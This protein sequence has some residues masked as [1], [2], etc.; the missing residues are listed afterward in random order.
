MD[1][2]Q[3]LDSKTPIA[4][5]DLTALAASR[6]AFGDDVLAAFKTQA[7]LR[8]AS[9]QAV[10]TAAETAGRDS[11]LAS[12]QRE[13]DKHTRERDEV[14]RL[15]AA[16]ERRTEQRNFV[17][18]SQSARATRP[19]GTFLGANLRE[20]VGNTGAGSYVTPPEHAATF[21]DRLA[22]ESIALSSGLR[23][24]TTDRDQLTVPRIE[25]D[26]VAAWTS[27]GSEISANDPD[28]D[29][30]TATPRKLAARV[31]VSNELIAD[32]NPSVVELLEHQ[33]IRALS[34]ELDRSIFKGSG[35]PPAIRG[36]DNVVGKLTD[37]SF[38]LTNLDDFADAIASLAAQNATAT[39]IVMHPNTWGTLTKLKEMT[40]NSNKPVLQTSAGSGAQGVTRAIYGVP[41]YVSS[42]LLNTASPPAADKVYIY[43]ASQIVLVRRADIRVEVDRS[44][45]FNK[46]QSEIR[47]ILR[48]DLVVPNPRAVFVGT[49]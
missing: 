15:A 5:G 40:S 32:S 12:E 39:A 25:S 47:A 9:A 46:D 27:E 45:L 42:Q 33:L 19:T 4:I 11:L 14:L 8:T 22:A 28:I 10:L 48:A 44:R 26:P 1:I 3:L 13:Y 18:I 43:D 35:T 36:L 41:V 38:A 20:L 7:E 23:V 24:I 49:I 29:E 31:V 2:E 6:T 21:F 37:G 34:L 30:V 16:V 17:P